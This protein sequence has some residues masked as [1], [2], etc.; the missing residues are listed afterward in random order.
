MQ[1]KFNVGEIIL[2][3]LA[4][5]VAGFIIIVAIGMLLAGETNAA[6]A[7]VRIQVLDLVKVIAGAVIGIVSTMISTKKD[8]P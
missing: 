1:G 2:L 6:N 3:T 8:K 5:T 4:F 7:A